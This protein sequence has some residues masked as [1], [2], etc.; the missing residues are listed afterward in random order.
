MSR[1]LLEDAYRKFWDRIESGDGSYLNCLDYGVCREVD[2]ATW[3]IPM[4]ELMVEGEL[5]ETINQLNSWRRYLNDLDIWNLVLAEYGEDDSLQIALHFVLQ[6]VHF[7]M[8]QPAA[9][10]DLLIR[11]ATNGIHQANLICRDGYLDLL[12]QD[13]LVPKG[14]EGFLSRR[15]AENQLRRV[16]RGWESGATLLDA[17][18]KLDNQQYR[19]ATLNYRNRASHFIAPRLLAGQVEL[20]LRFLTPA[21]RRVDNEDGSFSYVE[22]PNKKVVA[23]GLGGI[24]PFSLDDIIRLNKPQYLCAVEALSAYQILL[25]E[26]IKLKVIG[27]G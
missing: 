15:A 5:R 2:A 18:A 24:D 17:L 19:N 8:H 3:A 10:R 22:V 20:Y 27:S 26:A 21:H 23:Y 1:K 25:R 14:K 4:V 13:A 12:D 6:L 9:I 7:C 16:S 11:V